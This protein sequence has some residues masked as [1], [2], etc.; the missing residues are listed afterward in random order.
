MAHRFLEYIL[1]HIH[2][3]YQNLSMKIHKDL[4]GSGPEGKII[5]N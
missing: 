5:E 2:S 1:L 3:E 4:K